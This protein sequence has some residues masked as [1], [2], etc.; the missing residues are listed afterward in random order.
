MSKPLITYSVELMKQITDKQV[1]VVGAFHQSVR[2]VLKNFPVHFVYQ[3]KRLGTGH[4]VSVGIK[5]IE[6]QAWSPT[7]V[8]VGYGDHTMF[9]KKHSVV[10]LIKNHLAQQATISL[11]TFI[12]E[13][14]DEK[15]YGRIM[16]N[17]SGNVVDIVEQKDASEEQRKI[18]E[19][20]PG[21]YCFDYAFLRR[22]IKKLKKSEAS[23]EYYI[24][25]MIKIAS[26]Q[27]EKVISLPI[28]YKEV[29]P[30]IN[31]IEDLKENEKLF[32]LNQTI[33]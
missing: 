5:E 33:S 18:K 32:I 4:A 14:P 21:F 10:Q 11:L 23:S 25:D 17:E 27:G 3:K 31:T 28:A 20:N 6:K 2:E 7:L 24:T 22:S 15:K 19:V 30:G 8:L 29:G 12:Y 13:N 9:Y 1:V 26:T 16:R